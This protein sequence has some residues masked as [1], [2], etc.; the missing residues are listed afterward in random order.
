MKKNGYVFHVG[1]LKNA[2]QG[3]RV[4]FELDE[5]EPF[6]IN[7]KN[8]FKAPLKAKLTFMTLE[9][10]IH[11]NVEDFSLDLKAVCSKCL[12]DF[13]QKIIIPQMERVYFFEN[14]RGIEV[15]VDDTFYV[16]MKNLL[17]DL[18]EFFRQEI[19]LHFP[20]VPVCL[21]SCKG[22]CSVCG[23]NLNKEKCRCKKTEEE[24]KPLAALKK[25]SK[26]LFK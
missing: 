5:S 21:K 2:E 17:I 22:L 18:R 10:G 24:I 8:E 9:D 4:R 13:D 12:I 25:L 3:T 7:G 19:I 26:N 14:Q 6:E 1:E 20:Q 11:V 15:D 23:K 16:D